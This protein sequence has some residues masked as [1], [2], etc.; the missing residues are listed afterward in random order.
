MEN[1]YRVA[2]YCRLSQE[3]RR[4]YNDIDESE[5]IQNQKAMLLNYVKKNNWILYDIYSDDDYS[6][7]DSNR[8]DWNRMLNDAKNQKFDVIVCK[9]Q[10]RFT[11]DMEMV[12]KYLNHLF[13]I[14]GI[15]FLS[16]V[17]NVDT[18]IRGS[19]KSRQINGLTN[20]WYVE[21]T[22]ESVK[23]AL[24]IMRESGKY[25]AATELYGY[26]RDPK[27]K[28]KLIVN[29]E[30]SEVIKS[31]YNMYLYQNMGC[32]T[33]AKKLNQKGI[34]PPAKYKKEKLIP[35]Y[36]HCSITEKWE[37]Y[38]VRSI[39][40]N[41]MYTG[42]MVQGKTTKKDIKSKNT[43]LVSKEDW[44]IVE[45]THEAIIS[46]EVYESVQEK[47]KSKKGI[48][49]K[50]AEKYIFTGKLRCLN[51]NSTMQMRKCHGVTPYYRCRHSFE[52]VV[53]CSNEY[54]IQHSNLYQV[55]LYAIKEKINEYC[56]FSKVRKELDKIDLKTSI[57]SLIGVKKNI[58]DKIVRKNKYF[59]KLYE[60]MVDE[61]IDRNEYVMLKNKYIGN[62]EELNIKLEELEKNIQKL[63]SSSQ[64][65]NKI[66]QMIIKFEN[67]K[68]LDESIINSF[69]NTIKIGKIQ[70]ESNQK[71]VIEIYWNF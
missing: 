2:I 17:D 58:E 30:V 4:K 35:T 36:N 29:T 5:S 33:I 70:S 43:V 46:K 40:H 32:G 38:N 45:N 27:D 62:I 51:C 1:V 18:H 71:Q 56:N 52:P 69:I 60:D 54:R 55:I 3:D 67:L 25:I 53:E 59:G 12:E 64:E 57:N 41:R 44:V 48:S 20:Q 15:R 50:K 63:R 68:E 49:K 19:K 11:R 6:G 37:D 8:P 31:I 9:T 61:I 21:D 14:W 28:T 24:A 42:D 47:F 66:V 16:I 65:E 26:I 39:L 10:S 7:M 23:S 22:S 34:L 13:E